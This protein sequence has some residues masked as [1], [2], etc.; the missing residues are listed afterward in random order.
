MFLALQ[1]IDIN[2]P[3]VYK[4]ERWLLAESVAVTTGLSCSASLSE[5]LLISSFTYAQKR[6]DTHWRFLSSTRVAIY[7]LRNSIRR[8]RA[9]LLSH[10]R[11]P[12]SRIS[13]DPEPIT[14]L[15]CVSD[16]R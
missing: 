8:L 16:T 6:Q 5:A 14:A 1:V 3:L 11:F 13:Y 4:P 7:S 9:S 2:A 10:S 15:N 12:L